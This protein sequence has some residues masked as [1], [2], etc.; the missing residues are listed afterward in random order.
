M[1]SWWLMQIQIKESKI[2]I[3][4]INCNWGLIFYNSIIN[5]GSIFSFYFMTFDW[6]VSH[7]LIKQ[8]SEDKL[9]IKIIISCNPLWKFILVEII[10][11]QA[12]KKNI[13]TTF[14]PHI[15]WDVVELVYLI[16][17]HIS[18]LFDVHRNFELKINENEQRFPFPRI[19]ICLITKPVNLNNLIIITWQF[20]TRWK[21][22]LLRNSTAPQLCITAPLPPVHSL[23]VDVSFLSALRVVFLVLDVSLSSRPA[24]VV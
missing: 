7:R 10:I 14:H 16:I 1:D 3:M 2:F 22:V 15:T 6:L 9:M 17:S 23:I 4:S 18:L 21:H 12:K 13:F 19:R 11:S 24:A 20:V 8:S 5:Y